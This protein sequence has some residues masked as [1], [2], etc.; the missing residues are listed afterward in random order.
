MKWLKIIALHTF[1][2]SS[3]S[4]WG[5]VDSIAA[6]T[7]DIQRALADSLLNAKSYTQAVPIYKELHDQFPRDPEIQY[8]LGVCY[9]YGTKNIEMA[10]KYLKDA[11]TAEVNTMVYFHLAEALRLSYQFN[12]AIDYYRRFVVS[13]GSPDIKLDEVEK[14]VTTCENGSFLTRYVYNPTV[15]DR[16]ETNPGNF[17]NLYSSILPEGSFTNVPEN[18]RT[19]IDKQMNYTGVMF[20]PKSVKPGDYLYY[21]SYGKST[22][23]GT[24]IFRIQLMDNGKWSK[25]E[26]LGDIIN[27]ALNEE[28][29]FLM[30]DGVT[31]YFASKGHYGM[32]GYDIYK[33]VY[34]LEKK[35]WSTPENLG[36][37]INSTYD[38][39]LLLTGSND[40][41][42][43]FT[44]NRLHMP[45]TL[46]VFLIRND[47][48][49]TRRT[50]NS[51]KELLSIAKLNPVETKLSA[52]P[53]V[54]KSKVEADKPKPEPAENKKPAKFDSVE[55]DPEYSRVLAKGFAAQK[56]ADSLKIKLEDLRGRFDYVTTAEQRVRLEKQV[57]KVED[58][59]LAAQKEADIQFA[60]ASQIE[61]EYLTGKRKPQGESN[62]SFVADNP[63]FI[64]QAQFA[65]TVFRTDE[66]NQLAEAEKLTPLLNRLI[67][68]ALEKKE[69]Y[70]QC[71]TANGNNANACTNEY[72]QMAV[73][74]KQYSDQFKKYWDKKYQIYA[75]CIEVA[76]VKSGNRDEEVRKLTTNA[77]NNFRAAVA[78]LNNLD[79]AGK[80]ESLFEASLLR[81]L[82]LLQLDLAFAKIWR[83][84]LMEQ[85]LLSNVIKLERNIF[86]Q[87]SLTLVQDDQKTT[88]TEEEVTVDL[89]KLKNE[90]TIKQ[91][92][93]AIT[94]VDEI[95]TDFGIVDKP[96]YSDEKPIP[97]DEPLPNGVIYRIQ[98]GAFS[99][100]QKPSFFKG[101]VPI[102]GYKTGNIIRY[103][104]GNLTRY[105]DA[106][107][108]LTTVKQK[109]FKD[110]FIVAWY[111]GN[112]VTTQRAQQLEG[113]VQT[114]QASKPE[115][116]LF[117]VEVGR[118]KT[119]LTDTEI[120]T[121]RNLSQGKEL[122]RKVDSN[123]DLIYIIG[124]FNSI[125]EANR[126]KENLIASGMLKAIVID[127]TP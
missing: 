125:D 121:I 120:S 34:N 92:T 21:S 108:A 55:N 49:P 59:M 16:K 42:A 14:L 53:K 39:F 79:S 84:R 73:A 37:P 24:D 98:I 54:K 107:K 26:N 19:A 44:S 51:Y 104:I 97:I 126:V 45:D 91:V 74:M 68:A 85:Q 113:T 61:Q 18:L 99:T 35:Q 65:S 110:A 114:V 32:G 58:D 2:L 117:I 94:I 23:W 66:I 95:P 11:S 77:Q 52:S 63:D 111:N 36:F 109:G 48:N 93:P 30:P 28:Y 112:R 64:Y 17:L 76:R 57:T 124:N 89:P 106:E 15:F 47:I 118:Y 72:S 7:G 1:F 96:Y 41:L 46:N 101:M 40:T 25:P 50:P 31:L 127:I 70:N 20:Y 90:P 75:D 71:L 5:Q 88:K 38:D 43:C 12:D 62:T 102:Y 29:P 123:G 80:T 82:G 60:R 100:P 33:S 13:G 22:S 27:S 116:Q 81:N 103:Y 119:P 6:K 87:S 86:G 83:L 9:L 8:A 56:L 115:N 4:S 105:S 3:V 67:N 69:K 122:T 78:I 10:L